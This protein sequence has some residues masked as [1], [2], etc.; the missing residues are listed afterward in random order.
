[1]VV[2]VVD[3]DLYSKSTHL[4][5]LL[6]FGRQQQLHLLVLTGPPLDLGASEQSCIRT[7]HTLMATDASTTFSST[8]WSFCVRVMNP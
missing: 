1:M 5:V 6:S 2:A 4:F 8:L 7:T 3:M